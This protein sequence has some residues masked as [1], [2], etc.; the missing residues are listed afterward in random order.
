MW[1][2]KVSKH[3]HEQHLNGVLQDDGS[4]ANSMG[5]NHW[6]GWYNASGKLHRVEGPA[7]IMNGNPR[8]YIDGRQHAFDDWCRS[9]G[10]SEETK[11]ML[12]LQYG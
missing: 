6:K 5:N 11:M 4:Y 2:N 8:W 7:I 3:Y 10:I 9:V 1:D 12:R